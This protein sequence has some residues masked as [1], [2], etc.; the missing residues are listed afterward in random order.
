MLS[1]SQN[2]R[3]RLAEFVEEIGE[4]S[5]I[6][7]DHCSKRNLPCIIMSSSTMKCSSCTKK[8]IKCVNVSWDVLNRTRSQ[9]RAQIDKDTEEVALI[10]ARIMRNRKVLELADRR[11][12]G[13]AICVLEELEVEEA[14]EREANGG[15]SNGEIAEANAELSSLMAADG[16]APVDWGAMGFVGESPIASGEPSSGAT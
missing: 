8:G 1:K 5:E 3:K 7:C 15:M 4:P 2:N 11:A 10:M 9:T 12:R 16:S 14:A 13:K 6:V